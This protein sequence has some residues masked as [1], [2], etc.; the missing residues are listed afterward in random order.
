MSMQEQDDA[1]VVV[2]RL[3]GAHG[4]KGWLKVTSFTAPRENL[5][6]YSPW[7][8]KSGQEWLERK[9]LAAKPQGKG[10]LVHFDNVQ[11]R[12]Q[13]S[14]LRGEE[15]AIHRSQLPVLQDDEY[16]WSDL[17]GLEVITIEDVSLG[18]IIEMMATGS[19]DVMVVKNEKQQRLVPFIQ[20]QVVHKVDLANA[21]MSV[22]WD[23]EF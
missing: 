2:G 9:V 11:D 20:G 7:Y 10:L 3:G 12:D 15:V 8:L 23:P 5:L 13:A 4:I 21:R 1:Y 17:V 6:D 14:Q 16:Y 19:N 22:D 18:H